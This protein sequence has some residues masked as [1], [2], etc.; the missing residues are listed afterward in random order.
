MNPINPSR[1]RQASD[2]LKQYLGTERHKK[3]IAERR[4]RQAAFAE[5]LTQPFSEFT[6]AP[7]REG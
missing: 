7:S 5:L 1:L 2:L 6:S 4:Q 3:D